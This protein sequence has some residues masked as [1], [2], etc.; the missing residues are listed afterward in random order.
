MTPTFPA[1]RIGFR[2]NIKE[3]NRFNFPYL[4]WVKVSNNLY[5][6]SAPPQ[7]LDLRSVRL[8]DVQNLVRQVYIPRFYL[9]SIS[10]EAKSVYKQ[11]PLP[12]YWIGGQWSLG[13]T[14]QY[15]VKHHHITIIIIFTNTITI[16]TII[17]ITVIIKPSQTKYLLCGFVWPLILTKRFRYSKLSPEYKL[18]MN[19]TCQLGKFD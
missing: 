5:N 2:Y 8:P 14:S 10:S 3:T 19:N 9:Q 11:L 13:T 4:I 6:K 15:C 7:S 17:S 12:D 18:V 16:T 1:N